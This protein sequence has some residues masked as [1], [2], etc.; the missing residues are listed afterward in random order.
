M[1]QTSLGN[2]TI[3]T[4]WYQSDG[5]TRVMRR[6]VYIMQLNVLVPMFAFGGTQRS[7]LLIYA[8]HLGRSDRLRQKSLTK[9]EP[10]WL[11]VKK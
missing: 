4:V 9:T 2:A 6:V 10:E 3:C 5:N 1:Y 8:C 7:L 11:R